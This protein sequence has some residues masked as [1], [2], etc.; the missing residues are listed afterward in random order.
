MWPA[1]GIGAMAHKMVIFFVSSNCDI[2]SM[3]DFSNLKIQFTKYYLSNT[4]RNKLENKL[5]YKAIIDNGK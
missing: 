1:V 4:I 5:I 2:M 3:H